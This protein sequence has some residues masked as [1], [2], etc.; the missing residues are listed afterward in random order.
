MTLIIRREREFAFPA[1]DRRHCPTVTYFILSFP[2]FPRKY[3]PWR[4]GTGWLTL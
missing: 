1:S 3:P 2:P 4:V